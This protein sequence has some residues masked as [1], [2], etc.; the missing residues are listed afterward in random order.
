MKE[1]MATGLPVLHIKDPLNAGQVVDGVNG[2]IY[3]NAEEMYALLKRY[4]AMTDKEKNTLTSSVINSVKI[5]G[6]EALAKYLIDVYEK[7]ILEKKEKPSA[8][9][10][11]VGWGG[12]RYVSVWNHGSR[13]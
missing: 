12:T 3:S 5:Y 13:K 7:A 2:F 1:A 11:K 8:R 6:C 10:K 4:Q 9:R